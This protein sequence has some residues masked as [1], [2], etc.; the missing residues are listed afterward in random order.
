MLRR[1]NISSKL[2][3]AV[4]APLLVLVVLGLIGYPTFQRVKINGTEYQKIDEINKVVADVSPPAEF[5][6]ESY[7]IAGLLLFE[8]GP[9]ESLRLERRLQGLETEYRNRHDYWTRYL[10]YGE[11]RGPL[12]QETYVPADQFYKVLDDTFLPAVRAARDAGKT[13]GLSDKP[14][15][16]PAV[17]AFAGRLKQ[18]FTDHRTAIEKVVA[19]SLDRQRQLESSARKQVSDRLRL[20]SL[21]SLAGLALAAVIGTLMARSISKPVRRLTQLAT[22]TANEDL[23]AVVAAV[24]NVGPNDT[25]PH[26]TPFPVD[27]KNE[28][29]QLARAF[30]S[31]QD[32]AVDL[33][34]EQARIRRNVSENLVNL[35]RRNQGLLSRTLG[36]IS[37]LE[38]NERDPATLEDLFRLDHL[39]TR[40]RRNAES[41]LVLAGAE[42]T[43]VWSE[44]V[45]VGDVVRAA[46]SEI[47]AYDRVD[48]AQLDPA[49]VK[50]AAVSDVVHLIAE[51]M[52]NATTFSPPSSR[53]VVRGEQLHEG[54]VLRI[55]D[56]G[57]GMGPSELVQ[58]NRRLAEA[59]AFDATPSKVL[60][61]YVVGRLALRHDVKVALGNSYDSL[62]IVAQVLLPMSLVGA[63][64]GG[65]QSR[66]SQPEH[67]QRETTISESAYESDR[68]VEPV[69]RVPLT[70]PNFAEVGARAA[71][72][73]AAEPVVAIEEHLHH[74]TVDRRSRRA[75]SPL[76][77]RP[78]DAPPAPA[79][80]VPTLA[81][82]TPPAPVAAPVGLKR[83]V[84][85]AQM[86][87]T[88]PAEAPVG[89][90]IRSAEEVRSSLSSFQS[91]VL[92]GKRA[93]GG[94]DEPE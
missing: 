67:V 41:L 55:V 64:G 43:R 92:Q 57:I 79:P 42:P 32:T 21:A 15:A 22:K 69:P 25:V 77:N 66:S 36:F 24:Q 70:V 53:V 1:L 17:N 61:H 13:A 82:V 30:N 65:A 50:G 87:D 48:I 56:R 88:G 40:M 59:S 3:I 12:L 90:S 8:S 58:A 33:A 80:A 2:R 62:G 44:P 31:V 35:G 9:D 60:G 4:A 6:A 78:A 27:S 85:G 75:T 83:R 34:A 7:Q 81:S 71:W 47:E 74:G 72:P 19:L 63:D 68:P 5:I 28:L 29:G 86:P 16:N 49:K 91:G 11:I 51:L 10:T 26:P 73:E 39:T 45:D 89:L 93:A 14:S 37:E 54:Y 84:R 20:L 94:G 23:P 76:R 52:E 46:L 18:L 38:E